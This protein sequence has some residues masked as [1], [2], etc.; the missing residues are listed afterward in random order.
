MASAVSSIKK[1]RKFRLQPRPSAVLR[2]LKALGGAQ[3]TPE[4][5]QAV[6]AEIRAASL[7]TAA[8][9]ATAARAEAPEWSTP[10]WQASAESPAPVA[11]TFFATT[12]GSF[13]EIELAAALSRG[14]TFRSQVLT[15]LGE[16]LADQAARF[17]ERLA[18]E[19]ARLDSC[20]VMDRLDF[21][22]PEE[23]G[24]ALDWL[25]ASR[26]PVSLDPAGR[27]APRFS[28]VGAI[29]WGPPEKKRK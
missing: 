5:D 7:E 16:E 25:E 28:R 18:A 29:P 11:L 20:E 2:H 21:S 10:Y 9:Y 8:L 6:E 23:I 26:A 27:I 22:R 14:E 17:V 1:I 3:E 12:I 15:A 19:E 13:F 24:R 4:L